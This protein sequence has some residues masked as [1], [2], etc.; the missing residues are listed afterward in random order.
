MKVGNY[1]ILARRVITQVSAAKMV[2]V[3]GNYPS[4]AMKLEVS[5]F[6][7]K[8]TGLA[9]ADF[10]DAKSHKGFLVKDLENLR[11]SLPTA[12]KRWVWKAEAKFE[13]K[14]RKVCADGVPLLPNLPPLGG[15]VEMIATASVLQTDP[16]SANTRRCPRKTVNCPFCNGL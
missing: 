14:K 3:Y 11:R 2:E 5:C 12:D 10:F 1:S 7:A 16:C 8:L 6:L 13:A 9:A 15:N 4:T